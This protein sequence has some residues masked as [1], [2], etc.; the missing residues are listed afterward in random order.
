[1]RRAGL[2]RDAIRLIQETRKN[3][4]LEATDRI[5]LRYQPHREEAARALVEHRT[6]VA[7]EVLATDCAEGTP[8]WPDAESFTDEPLGLTFGSAAHEVLAPG[9]ERAPG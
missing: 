1:M 6:L 3:S 7:D 5:R 9:P 4:G 8:T 2:A